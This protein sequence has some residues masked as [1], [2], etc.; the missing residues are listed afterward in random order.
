MTESMLPNDLLWEDD[1]HLSDVALT[2]IADGQHAIVARDA[3][4]HADACEEC[5][6]RLGEAAL[7]SAAT[8]EA[9]A[10]ARRAARVPRAA[11]AT[12]IALAFLGA[13]VHVDRV[14]ELVSTA[15]FFLTRGLPVLVRSGMS[16]ARS[17]APVVSVA[18][19]ASA[20][21]L[22]AMGWLVARARSAKREGRSA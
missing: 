14:G 8:G 9:M 12:A 19:C 6:R 1:G 18:T 15:L 22:V 2:A 3:L 5:S 4:A 11:V 16:L 7:L 13:L 10:G 21:M 17:G 20:L